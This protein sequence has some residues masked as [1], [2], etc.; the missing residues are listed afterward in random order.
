MLEY[1]DVSDF[2][3]LI[4]DRDDNPPEVAA[5]P[6]D[7]SAATGRSMRSRDGPRGQVLAAVRRSAAAATG[8]SALYFPRNYTQEQMRDSILAATRREGHDAMVTRRSV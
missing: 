2:C 5:V 7:G 6:R 4:L 1:G 8:T 3:G